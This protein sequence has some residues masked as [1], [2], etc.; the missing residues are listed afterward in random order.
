MLFQIYNYRDRYLSKFD[1]EYWKERYQQSQWVKPLSKNP[2]GDDGLYTHVAWE[3]IHGTNP[4][5]LN[6]EMPFLGKYLLGGSIILFGN[7]NIFALLSGIAV[8]ITLFILNRKI[9]AN[10]IYAF[11]PVLLLS[12]EPLFYEQLRAPFFDLLQLEFLLLSFLFFLRRQYWLL[13]LFLGCFAATKFPFMLV[14]PTVAIVITLLIN[15]K[16]EIKKFVFTLPVSFVVYVLTYLRFFILGN[17][18]INFL[19]VQ[20]FIYTFYTT[21][22]KA[23]FIGTVFPFLFSGTWYTHFSTV[24]H[25]AE[26]SIKWPIISIISLISFI[27]RPLKH[28]AICLMVIWIILYLTFLS[29]TPPFPRYLLLL[30]PFLYNLFIWVISRSMPAKFFQR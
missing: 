26:W 29:L 2:V 10:D 14:L 16:R 23:P 13:S 28:K 15:D 21:G 22:A 7:Q 30:L 4:V 9:F 5:L 17:S 1:S 24:E 8:L 19:K 18:F 6:P 20:K 3:Y 27:Y 11:L 12:F 25:I